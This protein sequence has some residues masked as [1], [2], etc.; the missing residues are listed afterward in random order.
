MLNLVGHISCSLHTWA[1]LYCTAQQSANTLLAGRASEVAALRC[2]DRT[3]CSW[4]A[5]TADS[6][7]SLNSWCSAFSLS[8]RRYLPLL[9][10]LRSTSCGRRTN[11][12]PRMQFNFLLLPCPLKVVGFPVGGTVIYDNLFVLHSFQATESFTLEIKSS[13][14]SLLF[15][16][17]LVL[18]YKYFKMHEKIRFSVVKGS[19]FLR[20]VV[21]FYIV[22][23]L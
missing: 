5:S 10:L 17:I 9:L 11:S 4:P 13:V 19:A 2:I 21:W 7:L 18:Q 6:P 3:L 12:L 1:G 22:L 15:G 23:A 8:L 20:Y 16:L 14:L